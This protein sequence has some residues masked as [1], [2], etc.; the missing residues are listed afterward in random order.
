MTVTPIT[1]GAPHGAPLRTRARRRRST[2]SGRPPLLVAVSDDLLADAVD[3]TVTA[4]ADGRTEVARRVL[5]LLAYN[6]DAQ[7]RAAIA[8]AA[9][10]AELDVDGDMIRSALR[11]LEAQRLIVRDGP[12]VQG[13]PQTW[14]VLPDA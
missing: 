7:R 9:L 3:A 2:P 10:T 8:L 13:R 14:V 12:R 5:W 4:D 1:S 6:A 11:L